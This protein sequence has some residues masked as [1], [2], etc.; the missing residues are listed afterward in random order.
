MSPGLLV[1]SALVLL[2]LGAV[3]GALTTAARKSALLHRLEAERDHA[4][5]ERARAEGSAIAIRARVEEAQ[6]A[7]AVAETRCAEMQRQVGEMEAFIARS[8]EQ[9]EGAYS[10]LSDQALEGAIQKLLHVVKPHLDGNKNEVAST[11]DA[12][13]AEIEGLIGPLRLMLTTYQ[14][15][16]HRSEKERHEAFS[17]L[18]EQIRVLHT[19]SE[20]ATRETSRLATA[21]RAPQVSG[22]WGE[23]T[24][25]KC[26]E[27]AGMSP[28]CDF[29]WQ[30][31]LEAED[32]R[33]FRPDMIVRLPDDRVIAVDSKAPLEAYLAAMGDDIDDRKRRELMAQHAS[34]I[35]RHIES[36]SRKEYQEHIQRTLGKS[37]SFTILFISGEHFLS[38]A[39]ITD[40][41]IFEFAS[42]KGI[43]LA[44]PTILVP[45]LRALATGWKAEEQEESARK[46]L[47]L[48]R[49]FYQRLG[50]FLDHFDDMRKN[51]DKAVESYNS[52]VRSF[53]SRLAPKV[54]EIEK[55]IATGKAIEDMRQ[56]DKFALEPSRLA[57]LPAPP[58]EP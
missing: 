24:L 11:L 34:S 6:Q 14:E 53:D 7:R 43:V 9:L 32:N 23:N 26:V 10:K 39:M 42:S 58:E 28:F 41:Q 4:A 57:E 50:T 3:L 36:L 31:S 55:H 35:R 48:T 47:E 8:K 37:L 45:L 18:A 49:E 15:Q 27:L 21:L 17:G 51:L 38:A 12:K 44:S 56:I 40:P 19:A 16:L 52:A 20:S 2:T 13:K 30:Y 29:D 1:F 33:R 22:S 54:R 25:R 5:R 46:S